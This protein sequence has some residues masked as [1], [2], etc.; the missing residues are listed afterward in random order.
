[1]LSN[2]KAQKNK[3]KW[4]VITAGN[5]IFHLKSATKQYRRSKFLFSEFGEK[6]SINWENSV[7]E[8][9]ETKPKK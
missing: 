2:E 3:T 5:L 6:T 9:N 7:Y 8:Q 4:C 1:M